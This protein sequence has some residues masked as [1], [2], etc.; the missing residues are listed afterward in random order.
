MIESICGNYPIYCFGEYVILLGEQLYVFS[1]A[2]ELLFCRTDICD[3]HKALLFA[4]KTLLVDD[5]RCYYLLSMVDGAA[6]WKT[7]KRP[8]DYP[9]TRFSEP[10]GC[11]VYECYRKGLFDSIVKINLKTGKTEEHRIPRAHGEFTNPQDIL[12]DAYGVPCI[13]ISRYSKPDGDRISENGL[14]FDETRDWS[15]KPVF[16]LRKNLE[17]Y[18][19]RIAKAFLGNTDTLIT[20]DLHVYSVVTGETYNLIE[21]SPQWRQPQFNPSEIV[22]HESGKYVILK[23]SHANAIVDFS[24]RKIIAQYNTETWWGCIVGN[25][26]WET[27][28]AG[29]LRRPFPLMEEL[30]PPKY[31][32]W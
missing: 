13:L 14:L 18:S 25:E 31:K 3:A 32:F 23:Y 6:I 30:R 27:T 2:G 19:G 8:Q 26:F 24:A 7:R 16:N 12:C 5:R 20:S 9:L 11:Y 15:M 22:L 17:F 29:V 1:T 21:N 10:Y 4:D 28:E